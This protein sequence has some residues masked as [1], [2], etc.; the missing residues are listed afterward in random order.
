MH[1]LKFAFLFASSTYQNYG[2]KND[3]AMAIVSSDKLYIFFKIQDNL[4]AKQQCS[5][6]MFFII[7]E[8][9]VASYIHIFRL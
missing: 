7:V 3:F 2:L 1:V 6:D 4:I 5:Y 9:Y 8:T